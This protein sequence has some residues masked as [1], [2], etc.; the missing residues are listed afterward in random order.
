MKTCSFRV[1]SPD[2]IPIRPRPFFSRKQAERALAEFVERPRRMGQS[3]YAAASGERIPLD[4]L[5]TRCRI[6]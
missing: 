6:E 5:A 3:Y 1:I 2:G 4:K